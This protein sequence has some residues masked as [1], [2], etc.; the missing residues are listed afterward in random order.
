MSLRHR[1]AVT[2]LAVLLGAEAWAQAAPAPQ[3]RLNYEDRSGT[4]GH[5]LVLEGKSYGPYKQIL[6]ASYSTSG[7]AAAFAVLKRDK[8][9]VLA[10]G[11]ETGPLPLGFELDRLQVADDGKVWVLTATRATAAENEPNQTQLWVNGKSYGPYPELTTVEYAETGGAW[12][13]AVRTAAEEADVLVS[14]KAQGPFYTVDHAWL[15][16]D[17][18]SW[19]YAVSDSDGKATVVTSDKTWTGVLGAQFTNLYPREPH[20]GYSL[21]LGDEDERI[22][23]DG[24][25][26]QGYVNFQGLL[27]TPSGR[28]W[29]FEAERLSDAGGRVVVIDGREYA[30]ENVTWS[31]LGSQESYTWT[32]REGTKVTVQTLRLP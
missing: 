18:K 25:L 4:G 32:V 17:G 6:T 19:G 31:R 1:A 26:Y 20:W 15:T 23:V 24:Q 3:T 14:G 7:T 8:V 21:R 12:I 22:V 9:W 16:P 30:G 13:A 10:Q 11:K 5:L 29:A 2:A 27:L 28:H